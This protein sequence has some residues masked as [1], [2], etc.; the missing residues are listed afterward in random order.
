ME[1]RLKEI[2]RGLNEVIN[3]E[4]LTISNTCLF[5]QA[6]GFMRGELAGQSREKHFSNNKPNNV[7]EPATPKQV[8]FLKMNKKYKEGMTKQEAF[9]IIKELKEDDTY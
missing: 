3:E 6:C 2:I 5:E 7:K 8:A 4:Q 9:A 1:N